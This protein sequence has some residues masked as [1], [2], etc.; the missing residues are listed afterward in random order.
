M[1]SDIASRSR[2]AL[3]RLIPML[4]AMSDANGRVSD[5][6]VLL[7]RVEEAP[8]F[9]AI[10]VA[11]DE[12]AT[13]LD[14]RAVR[15]LVADYSGRVLVRL[16]RTPDATGGRTQGSENAESVPLAGTAYDEV[17]RT[18]QVAVR[19]LDEGTLVTAPV[20]VRGDAIGVMDLVLTTRPTSEQVADI[21]GIGHF[22][23]HIVV[24]NRRYT[25]LFEWG[26]RTTALSLSAEI[27]RRLLPPAF[28]CEA[29]QFTLAGWLE[30][31]STVGGDTFDYTL[32]REALHLSITD[33]AGHDVEAAML[34]T[35]LVSALRK[36][37]RAG[38]D[39]YSQ[40]T[41]AN[42]ELTTHSSVGWFVTGQ[43]VRIDL[44]RKT[45]IIVNAGHPSPLRLRRGRVEEIKLAIDIPFGLEPGRSFQLQPLALEPGD[46]IVFVTDGMLER[47]AA[48]LDFHTTLRDTAHL[49][50]REVVHA[51][52]AAV[53]RIT[54]GNLR[55]DATVLCLDWYGGSTG[56]KSHHGASQEHASP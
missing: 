1:P 33:A 46:R 56:R 5:L 36:A 23:G 35:V 37:R 32:D 41:S 8:P 26:Q 30:P 15:L 48:D 18:Q 12:L 44:D 40:V 31:A 6:R 7:E 10:D 47:N 9:D 24:V 20:T 52:G 55:D 51:L 4:S 34:A 42:D 50:P 49:H 39:L 22:L 3:P 16:G 27:Q 25:D 45:A 11:A 54:G 14:A 53:L 2:P 28:T 38:M 21:A 17:L 29:G 13:M 19:E 43:V